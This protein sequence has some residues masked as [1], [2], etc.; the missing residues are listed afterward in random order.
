MSDM[1]DLATAANAIANPATSAADLAVIAEA[2]PSLRTAVALH[3]NAYPGLLDWLDA[4]GDPTLSRAVAARKSADAKKTE[5]PSAPP[6]T[7]VPSAPQP[8]PSAPFTPSTS[9]TTPIFSGAG[10]GGFASTNV[11]TPV[12]GMY[13]T[14]VARQPTSQFAGLRTLLSPAQMPLIVAILFFVGA[15]VAL[16]GLAVAEFNP[17][18]MIH[19][20][21]SV[22]PYSWSFGLW[23]L[24][25]SS[26]TPATVLAIVAVLV[27]AGCG[28]VSLFIG[29]ND[30]RQSAF[31]IGIVLSCVTAIFIIFNLVDSVEYAS[32]SLDT[33][34]TYLLFL[35]VP[36]L[37]AVMAKSSSKKTQEQLRTALA[38]TIGT[39]VVSLGMYNA[40]FGVFEIFGVNLGNIPLYAALL[41]IAFTLPD[42][43]SQRTITPH[44]VTMPFIASTL[45]IAGG[46]TILLFCLSYVIN[47]YFAYREP[48]G[49]TIALLCGAYMVV[50]GILGLV[51]I[52]D[53]SKAQL[54]LVLG[55]GLAV[56]QIA[57]M[58]L[59]SNV[60]NNILYI[61]G[62]LAVAA[63]YILSAINLSKSTSMS[64]GQA[65]IG[66]PY[67]PGQP[68]APDQSNI[69]V[70]PYPSGSAVAQPYAAQPYPQPNGVYDAPSGGYAVLGF[71]IPVVGL[72]LYLVWKD[73][74]PL[75]AKSAG[76]GALIGVIV[77][78]G[79]TILY[80]IVI[81]VLIAALG[82][83]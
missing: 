77:Q 29:R 83:M 3:P 70:Q 41:L 55:V 21:I 1:T 11:G 67:T 68:Y 73:Q 31:L 44:R 34:L 23:Y 18:R 13:G 81:A 9:Q 14:N 76:K 58:W 32:V 40:Y 50:A 28:V 5:A 35:S 47:G 17:C 30:A 15:F 26:A 49:H 2:H 51:N 53:R 63:L 42:T 4:L 65:G 37:L 24:C 66:Q 62:F 56:A 54:L 38:I 69:A 16:I 79:V 20:A 6:P 45:A 60:V 27:L 7:F 80:Y 52:A 19:G 36:V 61:L 82:S 33:I 75:R 8:A 64:L 43:P 74:T 72:I 78:V 22:F 71:F 59:G 39:S 10:T 12:G 46:A 25:E 57:W 48:V